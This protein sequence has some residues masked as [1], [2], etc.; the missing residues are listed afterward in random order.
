MRILTLVIVVPVAAAV[1]FGASI[2]GNAVKKPAQQLDTVISQPAHAASATAAANLST[3]VSAAASYRVDHGSYMGMTTRDLLRYDAAL[4]PTVLVK[5]A[6]SNAYCMESTVAEAT[7]SI[8][9]P[10]GTYVTG[11]C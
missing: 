10:S 1:V 6:T 5:Q 4:A 8:R 2:L 7:V 11:S 3:A 9:G